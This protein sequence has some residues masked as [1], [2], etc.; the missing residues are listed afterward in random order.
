MASTASDGSSINFDDFLYRSYRG[1]GLKS[2]RWLKHQIWWFLKRILWREWPQKRQVAQVSNLM[3]SYIHLIEEMASKAWGGS[4]I[5]F[6]DVLKRSYEGNGLKSDAWLKHWSWWFLKEML[7][8]EWLQKR[9]ATQSSNLMISYIDLIEEIASKAWA[10]SSIKFDDFLKRSYEANGP[11]IKFDDFLYRSY[12]G[13][14]L[15]SVRWLIHPIWW[16]LKGILWREWPQK[17]QVAQASNLMIS[18]IDLIEEMASK[19]WVGSTIK[20]DG[21]LKRSYEANG[22]KRFRWLKHKIWGFLKEIL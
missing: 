15:Q 21:C 22:I 6:D 4:T 7:W 12:R 11:S 19:A 2:D 10:G 1:N 16:F 3:L 17:R 14:G 8:R 20:F 18:Y 9:Q 13:N 5:K